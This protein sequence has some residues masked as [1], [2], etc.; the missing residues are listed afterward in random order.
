MLN[1]SPIFVNGF[2]RGGTNI[3][4]NLLVSHPQ[5]CMLGGETHT[6]FYGRDSNPIKKWGARFL[7]LPIL[8]AARQHIFWPYRFYPRNKIPKFLTYYIDFLFYWSKMLAP[9]NKAKDEFSRNTR[10]EIAKARIVCKNVNGVVMTTPL[11]AEMYPDAT[12]IGLVRNGFA[13]CE[14]F[15]RRGWTA[16][17]FGSMYEKVCQQ[18]IDDVGQMD[19]YYIVRFED[20][21]LDP[22]NLVKEIYN[23]ANLEINSVT[24]FRLQAKRSMNKDGTR[25]YTF[26]GSHDRETQWFPLEQLNNGFRKDVNENQIARLSQEDREIFLSYANQAMVHLDYL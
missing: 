11:L 3:L 23:Y 22:V 19:N 20:I 18:M 5:V 17:R 25:N 15:M 14:G 4:M 10:Q 13:L 24:K 12:F 26:G 1:K 2:Q 7:Y 21:I 6:I 16:E 9:R 8:I